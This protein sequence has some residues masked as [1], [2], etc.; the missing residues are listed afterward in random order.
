[1][2]GLPPLVPPPLP[3]D[4][5]ERAIRGGLRR[6][7]RGYAYAGSSGLA[8]CLLVLAVTQLPG[9]S[10]SL[11]P[12]TPAVTPTLPATG[13]GVP[14]EARGPG[15]PEPARPVARPSGTPEPGT[16]SGGATSAPGEPSGRPPASPGPSD[17]AYG[18]PWHQ[19]AAVRDLPEDDVE[20]FPGWFI[21]TS[22][23]SLT[24]Q[25]DW[26]FHVGL[27]GAG[28]QAYASTAHLL[29]IQAVLCRPDDEGG[30]TALYSSAAEVLIEVGP[31]GAPV[32][33]WSMGR[34]VIGAHG[35]DIAAGWC[36]EWRTTWNGTN[37]AGEPLDPG[38]YE[39]RVVPQGSDTGGAFAERYAYDG[40]A[41]VRNN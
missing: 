33:T 28:E 7:H 35:K 3:V 13:V 37:D 17:P 15:G 41:D 23:D 34:A 29:T 10:S 36:V 4:G 9:G 12:V 8:A 38:R 25:G 30:G 5:L 20:Y 22:H 14:R 18:G 21:C 31:R 16:P 40:H 2:S 26:C 1:M 6:R 11:R 24:Y 39:L 19:P 32:W 27:T